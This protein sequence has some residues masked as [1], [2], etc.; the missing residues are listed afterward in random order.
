MW[1]ITADSV[2][3]KMSNR[4]SVKITPRMRLMCVNHFITV[5]IG[6]HAITYYYQL[7]PESLPVLQ[8]HSV[9]LV[10]SGGALPIL[11]MPGDH[12]KRPEWSACVGAYQM[13]PNIT[14]G[15]IWLY[16]V[17]EKGLPTPPP[18]MVIDDM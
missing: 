14:R 6:S 2:T 4:A 3:E 13:L 5:Y 9:D 12:T 15:V 16:P 11:T 8:K 10:W 1:P 7:L 18:P 17:R